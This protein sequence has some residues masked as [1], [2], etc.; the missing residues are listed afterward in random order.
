MEALMLAAHTG[1]RLLWRLANQIRAPVLLELWDGERI[2]LSENPAVVFRLTSPTALRY[3]LKP[4][5]SSLGEAFVEGYIDIEGALREI[6]RAGEQMAR[7]AGCMHIPA[8]P[9]A[10]PYAITTTSPMTSMRCGWIATW[11]IPAPTIKPAGRTFTPP[12]NKST[13]TFAASCGSNRASGCST[14][15]AAGAG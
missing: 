15:A 10:R 2:P 9:T 4:S 12:R 5:M 14:S 7:S 8:S 13:N 6:I 11:S 3:V 1:K